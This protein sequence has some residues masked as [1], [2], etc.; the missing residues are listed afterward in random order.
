MVD[1]I[2]SATGKKELTYVQHNLKVRSVYTDVEN[3]ECTEDANKEP[4]VTSYN[5]KKKGMMVISQSKTASSADRS[6][7]RRNRK[8]T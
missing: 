4:L 8:R 5:K 2:K 3:F 1:K 6:A 7:N